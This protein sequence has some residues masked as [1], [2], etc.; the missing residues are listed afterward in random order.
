MNFP[1]HHIMRAA[2]S[3]VEGQAQS[4]LVVTQADP[5]RS[6]RN[7]KHA[8]VPGSLAFCIGR[9]TSIALLTV[10]IMVVATAA[11]V[12]TAVAQ[13]FVEFPITSAASE[14]LGIA[15]GP[16]GNVWFT[17]SQETA[18]NIGR[19]TPAG[20]ITE[21]AVTTNFAEPLPSSP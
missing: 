3:F 5:T 4:R 13:T 1:R 21:F 7:K 18:G 15:T 10:I 16:D 14:P 19:I 2:A 9:L 12:T 17:E 6:T 20:V 11:A 8:L